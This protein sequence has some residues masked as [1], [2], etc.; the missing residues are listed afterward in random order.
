M[1]LFHIQ[2][3]LIAGRGSE[4]W[5][6]L[7]VAGPQFYYRWQHGSEP[8]RIIGEHNDRAVCKEEPNLTLAWGMDV[9]S[10]VDLRSDR[11]Y[12]WARDFTD[13]SVTVIWADVFWC[14]ALIDR[15]ELGRVDG[16]HG[17]VPMPGYGNEVTEFEVAIAE[18]IHS[19]ESDA[20]HDRPSRYVS[21]LGFKVTRDE[22]REG[23]GTHS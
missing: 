21:T 5:Y 18:L 14:G 2:H 10:D 11:Q 8:S 6:R 4:A 22:G 1:D 7:P 20:E 17:L 16:V 19:L 15:V 13:S 3:E 12:E 9:H 23:A